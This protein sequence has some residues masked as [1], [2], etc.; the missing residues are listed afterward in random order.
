MQHRLASRLNEDRGDLR[1]PDRGFSLSP[2][3]MRFSPT[4]L[5]RKALPAKIQVV[6]QIKMLQ[7][8]LMYDGVLDNCIC[9]WMDQFLRHK[10]HVMAQ[11]A[12]VHFEEEQDRL[13][14]ALRMNERAANE[15]RLQRAAAFA[16]DCTGMIELDGCLIAVMVNSIEAGKAIL[17]D[18][19]G[20][21]HEIKAV[22]AG[23]ISRNVYWHDCFGGF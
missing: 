11:A 20:Q 12:Q 5:M 8:F 7:F 6:F 22:R 3:K 23:C 2:V 1:S 18:G 16:Q 17:E 9:T 15:A 21:V 14:E 13:A 10:T 19:N 4:V